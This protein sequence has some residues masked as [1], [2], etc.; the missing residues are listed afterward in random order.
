M[1]MQCLV[2][3]VK[4]PQFFQAADRYERKCV[5]DQQIN[6]TDESFYIMTIQEAWLHKFQVVMN[7]NTN[8]W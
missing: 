5:S 6:D 2:L 1:N 3:I 4:I 8:N 7:R